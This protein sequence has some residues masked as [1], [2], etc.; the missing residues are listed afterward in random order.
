VAA[1]NLRQS[2]WENCLTLRSSIPKTLPPIKHRQFTS[3]SFSELDFRMKNII[4][5]ASAL[6][7]GA[8]SLAL[9]P[10]AFGFEGGTKPWTLSAGVRGF[11]DDNIF[12][13]DQALPGL[14]NSGK[15]D[16]FGFEIQPG[17]KVA[18][19]IGDGQTELT[20][21]YDYILRYFADRPKKI[22]HNHIFAAALGHQFSPRYRLDLTEDFVYAQ[23]PEQISTGGAVSVVNRVETTNYRNVAG[24]NF[25]AQLSERLTL[26]AA[27]QNQI[28]RFQNDAVAANTAGLGGQPAPSLAQS[29]NRIVH[30]PSVRLT[31]KV[32]PSADVGFLYQYGVTDFDGPGANVGGI[33]DNT[34]HF[35]AGTLDYSLSSTLVAS[36]RAGVQVY[37]FE[38]QPYTLPAVGTNAP[39]R[40]TPRDRDSV[41]PYFD[42]LL[43]YTYLPGS[44]VSLGVTHQLNP[45]DVD[46]ALGSATLDPLRATTATTGRLRVAH[47][48]TPAFTLGFNGIYQY[49]TYIG[50]GQLDGET[51]R[52]LSLGADVRYQFTP[53]FAATA[54]YS[55]DRFESDIV[56]DFREFKRNRVFLGVNFTY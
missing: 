10:A 51:D 6:T 22:D 5:A 19:P 3:R 34:S 52:Y 42:G 8:A 31:Y 11:Y 46:P 13:R 24:L 18:T 26:I 54:S 35:I 1:S 25:S 7:L 49:S 56:G 38:N 29:L 4:P 14:P 47:A 50:G 12:T 55:H 2:F 30:L 27:Y 45:T 41:A 32:N 15:A 33:R 23:E 21:S 20:A 9:V 39:V 36:L 44:T 16:S 40:V 17:I 37:S 43:T 48:F 53:N 28:H